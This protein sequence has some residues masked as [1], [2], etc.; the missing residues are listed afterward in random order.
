M[1][2]FRSGTNG[3]NQ[4]I[5]GHIGVKMVLGSVRYVGMI[6]RVWYMYSGSVRYMLVL[7]ILA[8]E[9]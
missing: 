2:K 5:G 6:V 7:E 3:L 9:S 8:W 4:E 1:C